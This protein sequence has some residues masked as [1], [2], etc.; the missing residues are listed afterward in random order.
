MNVLGQKLTRRER[1]FLA[2]GGLVFLV[3]ALYLLAYEP[4]HGEL[5]LLEERLRAQEVLLAEARRLSGEREAIE[6]DIENT[7][8]LIQEF[9]EGVPAGLD[10]PGLIAY[11][12]RS[13]SEAGVTDLHIKFGPSTTAGP[14]TRHEIEVLVSGDFHSQLAFLRLL[15]TMPRRVVVSGVEFVTPELANGALNYGLLEATYSFWV[16]SQEGSG[17]AVMGG[18]SPE[19]PAG[20]PDPFSPGP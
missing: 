13:A 18:M 14:Y 10:R 2:V 3:A 9:D 17:R 6:A 12:A 19:R 15:E 8:R 1:L 5:V 7:L 11:L 20:R 4:L 16:Y